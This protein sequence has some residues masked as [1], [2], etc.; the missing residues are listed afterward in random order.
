MI[1]SPDRAIMVILSAHQ[2]Q[3]RTKS[4]RHGGA[5]GMV[6]IAIAARS[7]A[8]PRLARHVR[9]RQRRGEVASSA[10]VR[11][12]DRDGGGDHQ[13]RRGA[14]PTNRLL[15]VTRRWTPQ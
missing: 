2:Q 11:Q 10:G 9:H 7:T 1:E 13:P 14:A 15:V 5:I 8:D 6:P 3:V 12:R 4:R